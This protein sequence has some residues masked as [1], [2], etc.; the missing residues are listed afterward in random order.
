MNKS[1]LT[2]NLTAASPAY[3]RTAPPG[4]PQGLSRARVGAMTTNTPSGDNEA[5]RRTQ[6][7]RELRKADYDLAH[8]TLHEVASAATRLLAENFSDS[9]ENCAEEAIRKHKFAD[10]V[11]VFDGDVL[12]YNH[13]GIEEVFELIWFDGRQE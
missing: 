13:D 6:R 4:L 2:S 12:R 3:P 9:I 7:E 10:R 1:S 11:S 5:I 8:E